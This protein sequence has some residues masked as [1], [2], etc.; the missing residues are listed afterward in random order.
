MSFVTDDKLCVGI[1]TK[2]AKDEERETITV[3]KVEIY[4][5]KLCPFCARAKHLLNQ[6]GVVFEEIDVDTSPGRRAEMIKRANGHYT[7]PQIFIDN[8]HVG[9]SDDLATLEQE[10]K[11]NGILGLD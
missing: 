7:V 10:G 11:L 9:G 8:S 4:S 2:P 5:S 6:K 1:H 3:A